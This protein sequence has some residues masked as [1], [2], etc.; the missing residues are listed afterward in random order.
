M[1]IHHFKQKVQ[2][3]NTIK[4]RMEARSR[5]VSASKKLDPGTYP[6]STV[7]SHSSVL[8]QRLGSWEASDHGIQ[9]RDGTREHKV[10]LSWD[11][12]S[13]ELTCPWVGLC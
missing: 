12:A 2:Y 11:K 3:E 5:S 6:H 13:R 9:I 10:N 1:F 8:P 7:L 4:T